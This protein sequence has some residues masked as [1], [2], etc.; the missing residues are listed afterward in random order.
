MGFT[1]MEASS[2]SHGAL[3]DLEETGGDLLTGDCTKTWINTTITPSTSTCYKLV[4]DATSFESVWK[5]DV[6]G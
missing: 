6:S 2:G 1:M 5:L 3:E 4:F